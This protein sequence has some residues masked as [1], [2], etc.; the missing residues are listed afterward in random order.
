MN[1]L[2]A[3][4]PFA[5][6]AVAAV[7]EVPSTPQTALPDTH[8]NPLTVDLNA[9]HPDARANAEGLRFVEAELRRLN[10]MVAALH[11]ARQG[12]LDALQATMNN[13]AAST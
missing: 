10:A 13:S 4:H 3:G 9:L 6:V 2:L 7:D 5:R 11:V 8:F 12:Y 1:T